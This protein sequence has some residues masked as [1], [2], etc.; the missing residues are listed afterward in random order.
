[1]KVRAAKRAIGYDHAEAERAIRIVQQNGREA[2]WRTWIARARCPP[3]FSMMTGK[4][5]PDSR[6]LVQLARSRPG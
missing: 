4:R 1:M 6:V 2:A 3:S 5:I